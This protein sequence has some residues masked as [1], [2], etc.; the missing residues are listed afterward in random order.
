VCQ[1]EVEASL[2][3]S[4]V[5]LRFLP[6]LEEDGRLFLSISLA[7][8]EEGEEG[9]EE[10]EGVEEGGREGGRE[11]GVERVVFRH[12]KEERT[13]LLI[14]VQRRSK[15]GREGGKEGVVW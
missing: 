12:V 4:L 7:E 15:G 2:P 5:L 11:G 13:E 10:G 3:P 9:R 6:S 8:E 1:A 14:E